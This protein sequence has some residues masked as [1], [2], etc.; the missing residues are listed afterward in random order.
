M[1]QEIGL[2][3][4]GP[5]EEKTVEDISVDPY[6]LD[7][8]F[9]WYALDLTDDND[10]DNLYNLLSKHYV[11]DDDNMFRFNYSREFLRWALMPPNFLQNWHLAVRVKKSGRLVG[12]ITAIPA[13]VRVHETV[14]NMVEINFLCVHKKL[15]SHRL[16]PVL[17]KEITR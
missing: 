2:E 3:D 4:I 14:V 15:R 11:E 5:I 8:N 6:P 9:E 7:P 12:C 13:K 17:I 1:D 10:L 16:A